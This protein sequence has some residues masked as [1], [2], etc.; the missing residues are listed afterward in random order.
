MLNRTRA[1]EPEQ[2]PYPC[3]T[4]R[5][6]ARVGAKRKEHEP[7]KSDEYEKN[8]E[9]LKRE[10][11]LAGNKAL[12]LSVNECVNRVCKHARLD[13]LQRGVAKLFEIRPILWRDHAGRDASER[14]AHDDETATILTV[15]LPQ[16]VAAVHEPVL[17]GAVVGCVEQLGVV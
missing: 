17:A 2:K 15:L 16:R 10:D 7:D 5:A 8:A 4:S 13:D 9:L 11:G 3:H 1:K 6:R 14:F 12:L